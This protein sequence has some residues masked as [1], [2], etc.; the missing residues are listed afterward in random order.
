MFAPDTWRI[1]MLSRWKK[2]WQAAKENN[3]KVK[4]WYHSDGNITDIIPDLIEA[5]VDVLNP[6]QPECLD[7]DSIHRRYGKR[8]T[9]DG[10]I[11]TQTTMPFGTPDD[12]RRTVKNLI[13]AYGRNGGLI[14]SPTHVLEPEVPLENIDAFCTACKGFGTFVR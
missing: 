2:V 13:D 10:C 7:I 5:G 14:L 1:M 11:G 9:L 12:V 8:L 3:P 6:I 4:I